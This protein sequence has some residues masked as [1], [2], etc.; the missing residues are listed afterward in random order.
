MIYFDIC[1]N[2]EVLDYIFKD[3]LCHRAQ[4]SFA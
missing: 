2:V 1:E 3:K 4:M